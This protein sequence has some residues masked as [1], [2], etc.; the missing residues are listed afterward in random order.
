MIGTD[1]P[2]P[3]FLFV[4]F[5]RQKWGENLEQALV[6]FFKRSQLI[7][8]SDWRQLPKIKGAAERHLASPV[9]FLLNNLTPGPNE[10]AD[11]RRKKSQCNTPLP[12]YAE[13]PGQGGEGW[14]GPLQVCNHKSWGGAITANWAA[15]RVVQSS[16]QL[17]LGQL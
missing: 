4:V 6:D 14:E 5:R 7:V 1:N 15:G 10:K 11:K 9:L 17:V 12:T 3:S 16:C 2:S 13:P 8:L